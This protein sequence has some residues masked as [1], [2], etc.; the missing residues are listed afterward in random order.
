M[1]PTRH[2]HSLS[3]VSGEMY[4]WGRMS[5]HATIMRKCL[6]HHTLMLSHL[7]RDAKSY[8]GT[9]GQNIGH[10]NCPGH[11]N[12]RDVRC[13]SNNETTMCAAWYPGNLT[14]VAECGPE[15]NPINGLP[16]ACA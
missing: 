16:Y 9:P 15:K 13:D 5:I 7:H 10:L 14:V 3:T 12:I 8:L 1:K 4:T 2:M 6:H 11:Y